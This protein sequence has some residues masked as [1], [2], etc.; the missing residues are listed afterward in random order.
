MGGL[1]MEGCCKGQILSKG[2]PRRSLLSASCQQTNGL[3]CH[4]QTKVVGLQSVVDQWSSSQIQGTHLH[5]R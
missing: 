2:S 3:L 4:E 5:V 1:E